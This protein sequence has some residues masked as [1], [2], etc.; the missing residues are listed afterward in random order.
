[1]WWGGVVSRGTFNLKVVQEQI[2]NFCSIQL[3]LPN[4]HNRGAVLHERMLASNF[5]TLSMK[6]VQYDLK[7]L[8]IIHDYTE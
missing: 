6:N 3:I 5:L 7:K 2:P 8:C 1:M 4:Y